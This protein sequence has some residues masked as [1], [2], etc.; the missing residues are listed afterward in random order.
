M[1]D[2]NTDPVEVIVDI[3]H[4]TEDSEPDV[5]EYQDI[6]NSDEKNLDEQIPSYPHHNLE[7]KIEEMTTKI[8]ESLMTLSNDNQETQTRLLSLEEDIEKLKKSK[9]PQQTKSDHTSNYTNRETSPDPE[10]DFPLLNQQK[11]TSYTENHL[12][13]KIKPPKFDGKEDLY[14]FIDSFKICCEINQWN[15]NATGLY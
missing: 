1:T 2:S 9:Y 15:Y 8:T 12:N 5:D 13:M 10:I 14:E 7:Q 11:D 6:E 3:N 4:H